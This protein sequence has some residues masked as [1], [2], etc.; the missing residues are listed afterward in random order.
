MDMK[1]FRSPG[2]DTALNPSYCCHF[3]QQIP[4]SI[5]L[6][7]LVACG[8][9]SRLGVWEGCGV[10]RLSVGVKEGISSHVTKGVHFI[11]TWFVCL[12]VCLVVHL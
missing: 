2:C 7:T 10:D 9:E 1:Y 6:A 8:T 4:F 3:P 12:F 11:F 5:T